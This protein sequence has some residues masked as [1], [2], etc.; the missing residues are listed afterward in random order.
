MH[1][2]KDGLYL[3]SISQITEQMPKRKHAQYACTQNLPNSRTKKD[4]KEMGTGAHLLSHHMTNLTGTLVGSADADRAHLAIQNLEGGQE[5]ASDRI[6][7]A[8]EALN[9]TELSVLQCFGSVIQSAQNGREDVHTSH[10][11]SERTIR[12]QKKALRDLQ[13]QG[14][15]TLPDFF[16]RKAEETKKKDDF[17][18]MVAAVK[19]KL[20]ALQ[21]ANE[22]EE[23]SGSDTEAEE[24][25][26]PKVV[27]E[28]DTSCRSTPRDKAQP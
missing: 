22:E 2:Y 6:G 10:G 21:A 26:D 3:F 20:R 16:R 23:S 14:F 17:E 24:E 5:A 15:Q 27:L 11:K 1:A 19:A 28:Q 7:S 8:N 9:V 13:A 12:R 4:H 25:E 18:A